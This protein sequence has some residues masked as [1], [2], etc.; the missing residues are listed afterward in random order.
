MDVQC[1]SIAGVGPG[2]IDLDTTSKL[3]ALDEGYFDIHVVTG[4]RNFAW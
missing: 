2:E 4:R 3:V 1:Y